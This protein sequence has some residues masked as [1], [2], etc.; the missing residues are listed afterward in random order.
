LSKIIVFIFI[1]I[2]FNTF[3]DSISVYF[4]SSTKYSSLLHLISVAIVFHALLSVLLCHFQALQQ[5]RVYAFINI[6]N[7]GFKGV[8]VI[9][10]SFFFLERDHLEYYILCYTFSAAIILIYT[11]VAYKN[12]NLKLANFKHFF[13]VYKLGFWIFLSSIS[14][15]IMTRLDIIM[16][17]KLSSSAE[18][19]Y[20]SIA[21]QLAMIFPLIT[22][23]VT[24]T[25]LP[26]V[27]G[28]VRQYGIKTYIQR[29]F[30][31]GWYVLCA[32]IFFELMSKTTINILLGQSYH[33][34]V[35]TFNVLIIA[36]MFGV[37]INPISLV[38]YTQNKAHLL[39]LMNFVQLIFNIIGNLL[40]IPK[41][42]AVGAALSTLIVNIGSSTFI[43]FYLLG[44]KS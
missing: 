26:K 21:S 30:S 20:Y 10:V 35:S 9:G 3:T 19:G 39:T 13:Q 16:L 1:F 23:S 36:F 17:Q 28:F 22:M 24:T 7:H 14:V 44:I 31:K 37:I 6:I 40:L 8:T 12:I 5:F 42:G 34:S 29:V 4:F 32:L 41:F 25:M 2:L 38:F 27:G 43:I 18:V 11:L 33:D 15:I